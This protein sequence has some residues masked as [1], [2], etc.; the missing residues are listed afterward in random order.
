MQQ[1]VREGTTLASAT[2][3]TRLWRGFDAGQTSTTMGTAKRRPI[4]RHPITS[5]TVVRFFRIIL[6]DK[7]ILYVT[8]IY[9]E[10]NAYVKNTPGTHG[11]H[12]SCLR[13]RQ[14]SNARNDICTP[15]SPVHYNNSTSVWLADRPP[16]PPPSS[17]CIL[18]Y[19]F[20]APLRL[21]VC[22]VLVRCIYYG[23]GTGIELLCA[24]AFGAKNNHLVGVAFARGTLLTAFLFIPVA[25]LW[26]YM[27]NIMIAFG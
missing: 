22:F 21:A 20:C 27:E 26:F 4:Q 2:Q 5:T 6:Q 11:E 9:Q 3:T 15:D 24:Q 13:L 10:V 8:P 7:R 12:F 18:Q 23:M 14:A 16:P 1:V 19:L 25:F 17:L